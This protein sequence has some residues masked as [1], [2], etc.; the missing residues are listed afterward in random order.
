MSTF[1][2]GAGPHLTREEP[3]YD[4][5]TGLRF[6]EQTF[7]G[8]EAAIKGMAPGLEAA[9]QS[10]TISVTNAVWEL[11]TRVPI[12]DPDT[13]D[14]DRWEISTE[15]HEASI[16][17]QPDVVRA[18]SEYDVL[19]TTTSTF[20]K[21]CEDAVT[22]AKIV[23]TGAF[24]QFSSDG[25]DAVLRHLRNGVTGFQYD[26]VLLRRFRKV[27]IEFALGTSG[28]IALDEGLLI[29]TTAQLNVPAAVFFTLPS[30]PS[31]FGDYRWGWKK[32]SQR[33]EII[34][35]FVEQTVELLFAPWSTLLYLD[36][37]TNLDW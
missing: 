26:F 15:A 10:Y 6:I 34:G 4:S 7:Q 9:G 27:S 1:K 28:Q 22:D 35:S 29:Y 25:F 21:L 32:R 20:R 13:E 2:G 24:T 36:S 17:E 18:A 37:G 23:L 12:N 16:F 33:V 11:Q 19:P 30:T 14:I 3:R 8:T 31:A 5:E